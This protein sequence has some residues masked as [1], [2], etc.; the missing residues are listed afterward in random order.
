MQD[1][2]IASACRT[3]IGSFLGTLKNT[4][5]KELG[6]I[7]GQEA[8]RRIGIMPDN[9][10]EIVCGNVIQAGVGG[11]ISRQIQGAIGIP[12][13]STVCTVNQLCTSSMRALEIG[14]HLITFHPD[15]LPLGG[16]EILLNILRDTF[17]ELLL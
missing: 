13:Q 1:V 14:C 6:R 11:N 7:V 5:V 2:I 15:L 12:W 3:P 4:P 10:D 9:V 8:I 17:S 16:E